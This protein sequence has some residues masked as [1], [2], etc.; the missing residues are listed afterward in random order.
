MDLGEW[1][2]LPRSN[3]NSI[4]HLHRDGDDE[5]GEIR[6]SKRNPNPNPRNLIDTDYFIC[7]SQDPPKQT[8]PNR[9]SG[10]VPTQLLQVPITWEPVFST[11]DSDHENKNKKLTDEVSV[12]VPVK[13]LNNPADLG[14][15]DTDPGPGFLTDPV[16]SPQ[17]SFK[18]MKENEFVDMKMD[19]A[20]VTSPRPQIDLKPLDSDDMMKI[21]SEGEDGGLR[22]KQ[23]DWDE[24]LI[25][26]NG[27]EKLNLWKMGLTGIG[28]ICSF[29]V[30]AAAA[31]ICVFLFGS[32]N[33]NNDKSGRNKNQMLRFQIYSDDK[34]MKEVVRQATK[35][36]EAISVMKGVPVVRAQISL[37]GYYNAL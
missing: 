32:N 4:H 1:E 5:D 21:G 6:D 11:D 2:L 7:P 19:P 26:E 28:A 37:G 18:R 10:M 23:E 25:Q 16:P 15:L 34:R 22:S 36:N 33:N 35:L 29:G 24:D 17:V 13:I 27:G 3:F 8:Q 31:T 9:R 30:A 14:F 12:V 20:R